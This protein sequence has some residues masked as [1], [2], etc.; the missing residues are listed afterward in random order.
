MSIMGMEHLERLSEIVDIH[1]TDLVEQYSEEVFEDGIADEHDE[2]G[3][4]VDTLDF[5]DCNE[6]G[7]WY[8]QAF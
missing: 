3:D 2:D 8:E 5:I 7:F 4:V 1:D 6:E